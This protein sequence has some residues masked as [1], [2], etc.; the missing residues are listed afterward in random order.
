MMAGTMLSPTE[1]QAV[2]EDP[3]FEGWEVALAAGIYKDAA[4]LI[5]PSTRFGKRLSR[6]WMF[7]RNDAGGTRASA[8]KDRYLDDLD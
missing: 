8:A 1:C 6:A 7:F 5:D 4:R 3:L 2:V